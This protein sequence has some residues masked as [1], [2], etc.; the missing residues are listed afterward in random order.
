M[1]DSIFTKIING[2]IPSEFIHED[3]HCVAIHDINPQAPV[4]ALVI[5]RKPIRMLMDADPEDQALLGHLML[6]A[7]KVAQDLGVEVGCRT[8]INNGESVGMTI[9]HLHLH[10]MGGRTYA[11]QNMG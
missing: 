2:E 4:H 3:E 5:P 8:V 1:S 11:E 6:V 7:A 9:Y 10:V